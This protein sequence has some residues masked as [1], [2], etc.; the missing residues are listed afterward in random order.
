MLGQP[1]SGLGAANGRRRGDELSIGSIGGF[2]GAA[3]EFAEVEMPTSKDESYFNR[4]RSEE[5]AKS[6]ENT[7]GEPFGDTPQLLSSE[8]KLKRDSADRMDES[9]GLDDVL[10]SNGTLSLLGANTFAGVASASKPIA[11]LKVLWDERDSD[12]MAGKLRPGG[13]RYYSRGQQQQ[14]WIGTLLP[15]LPQPAA[16]VNEPKSIWPAPALALSRSLLR[17]EKLAALAGGLVIER[18]TEGFAPGSDEPASR[19]QRFEFV[20]PTAWLGRTVPEGGPI[21]ITWC[22]SKDYGSINRTFQLGRVRASNAQDVKTLPLEL[23]DHSLAPLHRAF[24]GYEPK[25][26]A[27]GDGRSLVLISTSSNPEYEI[28]VVIDTNRSV[29]LSIEHRNKGKATQRTVFDDFT[30]AAGCWWARRV[31]TFD[32]KDRRTSRSTQTIT[33]LAAGEFKKAIE[34]ELAAKATVV[35]MKQPLPALDAAKAA[36]AAG[37]ASF[38]DHA[39]LT[40]HFAASQQWM[41]AQEHLQACEKLTAGKPGMRWLKD[42][43]LQ[44]SRRHE[45]LRK[46]L[47]DEATEMAKVPDGNDYALA[48]HLHQQA[49]QV[50]QVNEQI[51]L[52]QRLKPVYERQSPRLQAVKAWRMRQV[53]LLIQAGQVDRALPL[54]KQLATD[55]PQDRHLQHQHAQH[56]AQAGDYTAALAWLDETLKAKWTPYDEDSLRSLYARFLEQQSRH[57]QLA[58]F[59]AAWMARGLES[60]EPFGRHLAALVRSNQVEKAEA[61][62]SEWLKAGQVHG[63]LSPVARRRL[64]AAIPFA[65]GH[66]HG[67]Y[68]NRTPER[69]HTPLAEAA[70]AF[71]VDDDRVAYASAILNAWCFEQTDAVRDVRRKLAAILKAEA[72]TLSLAQLESF[73]LWTQSEAGLE[74]ADWAK[75]AQTVRTRWDAEKDADKRARLA[76]VLLRLLNRINTLEALAFLRVQYEQAQESYQPTAASQ[77]FDALLSRP[78][79]RAMEDEAFTILDK[80]PS[81]EDAG[82]RLTQRIAALHRLDDTM[83]SARFEALMK[84]VKHPETLTRTELQ[85]VRAEYRRKSR[86]D[87]AERLKQEAS[88]HGGA[89]AQWLGIEQLWL[90][91]LIERDLPKVAAE[92]WAILDTPAVKAVGEDALDRALRHRARAILTNLAARKGA[93]AALVERLV[94]FVRTQ[95]ATHADDPSWRSE[96]Y[97]L[98]IAIDRPQDLEAELRKWIDAAEPQSTWRLALADLLAEQG[99]VAEAVTLAEAVEKADEL[100]PAGYRKLA[101]WRLALNR[102][103]EHETAM[104]AVY[105]TMPEHDLSHRIYTYLHPWQNPG[106]LPT[107]FEP[108]VLRIYSVLFEKSTTPANYLDTLRQFYQSSREFRLLSMLADGVVGH[109]AAKVYPFILGMTGVLHEVGDE[110]TADELLARLVVVRAA[111]KTPVDHRALDLLELLVE[112]RA[113]ELQNQPGPHIAKALIALKRAFQREWSAGEPRLMADF[114]AGLGAISAPEL[115]REQLRQLEELHRTSLKDSFDRLHIAHHLAEVLHRKSDSARAMDVLTAALTEYEAANLGVLPVTANPALDTLIGITESMRQFARGEKMLLAQLQ[116]PANLEQRYW[117][118]KRHNQLCMEALHFD[119]EVSLGHGAALFTALE[120]KFAVDRAVP[121]ALQVQN[122]LMQSCRLYTLARERKLDEGA[123]ALK[124]FAFETLPPILLEQ[125]SHYEETVSQVAQTLVAAAGPR[126]ALAFLVNCLENEPGWRRY[127]GEDG[128][129]R[130][131][132]NIGMWRTR[133]ND[134]GDL[135]PRLLKLVLAELRRDLRTRESRNRSLYTRGDGHFWPEKAGDFAKAAEE[136]IADFPDS[137]LVLEHAAEYLFQNLGLC[138]RGVAVLA[139]AHRRHVLSEQGQWQLIRFQHDTG[140]FAESV[141][142]L[143]ALVAKRPDNISSYRVRLMHAYHRSGRHAELMAL[144]KETDER[145]RARGV[146]HWGEDTLAALAASCLENGLHQ[147]SAVYYAE[148][149]PHHQRTHARRGIGNGTLSGYYSQAAQAYSGLGK[150]REAVDMAAGAVVSWAPQQSQRHDALNALVQVLAAA[151]DLPEYA[152][153][154]DAEPLQSAVVRK[155][156]GKAF[157]Q[158]N[159]HARAVAQ[160]RLAAEL[161]PEDRETV[162]ALVLCLDK[163]G[164][165]DGAVS[166]LLEAAEINRRDLQLYKTLGDRYTAAKEPAEAE[167]AYTSIVEAQP[168]EAES[169]AR[170]AEV[171]QSQDRWSEALPHWRRVTELRALEPTGLLKLA[172]AQIHLKQFKDAEETLQKLHLQSWPPRFG[173]VPQ[174]VRDLESRLKR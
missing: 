47:L 20:S 49:Q 172:A 21:T 30:E 50:L 68:S 3:Y 44:A 116:H 55:H 130:H 133:V 108:E 14:L 134:L 34:A 123:A 159:D 80:M 149:I 115:A 112:R 160:L 144:L 67:L 150:T 36:A 109:T 105:K 9:A 164:D 70:R 53:G 111:A 127:T 58:E 18:R 17:A 38:D 90:E 77:L 162:D 40:V 168:K 138:D 16:E 73:D 167:R 6:L 99:K 33:V 57:R 97:R 131:A 114:L 117:L 103:A 23:A 39:A 165:R 46:R 88:K 93:E 166:Q 15:I 65:L 91:A 170:L 132:F 74:V 69:W 174:Q 25:V 158:K 28:R 5:L 151:K 89:F 113:A 146:T 27:M 122:I 95:I 145:F 4:N 100:S 120:K 104:A 11:G 106:H 94:T 8:G 1:F 96:L 26:E 102:R 156:I 52:Q 157:I 101:E 140:K 56:L 22:D 135:E 24:P 71:A 48:E 83:L 154:L 45:E 169:H 173:D 59:S 155:A 2:G 54:S 82:A 139:D 61:I 143:Q 86:E 31:E 62:A 147:Q 126:D 124:R 60:D 110:A 7:P 13:R 75:I 87:Y 64:D 32:E 153:S 12:G 171:R 37:T 72:A 118:V 125:D 79:S 29:I 136:V 98:L 81:T 107:K 142:L 76:A 92:C 152:A 128:W 10:V 43:Y 41:R 141:P 161:Q 129:S 119:G 42:A 66:G 19:G 137:S 121:D 35:L 63:V 78:W 84:A 148:L 163:V 85:K 51:E